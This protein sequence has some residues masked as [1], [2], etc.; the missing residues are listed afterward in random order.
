MSRASELQQSEEGFA[1]VF[2]NPRPLTCLV[3]IDEMDSLMP[4]THMEVSCPQAANC[5]AGFLHCCHGYHKG[6][7]AALS[8]LQPAGSCCRHCFDPYCWAQCHAAGCHCQSMLQPL[9]CYLPPAEC[10]L[11]QVANLLNEEIPQIYAACGRG[12]RSNLKVL[13]PGLAVTEMAVSPLPGNPTAV[14]T[15]KRHIGDDFDAYIIVSFTN[16]TLV[17]FEGLL[18]CLALGASAMLHPPLLGW[19]QAACLQDTAQAFIC[20]CCA[21]AEHNNLTNS[22]LQ[23]WEREPAALC[24]KGAALAQHCPPRCRCSPLVRQL[25]RS[26]IQASWPHPPP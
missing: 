23:A 21:A 9:L 15:I 25:R 4:V 2:F 13:R 10:T 17:S 24:I 11:M 12:P 19:L 26:A 18:Q 1:P 3:L 14:W 20:L 22:L 7:P 8:G 6:N 5:P 16:A